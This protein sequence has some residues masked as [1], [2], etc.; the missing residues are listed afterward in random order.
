[1]DDCIS[2]NAIIL[3]GLAMLDLIKKKKKPEFFKTP[4]TLI[5]EFIHC[6]WQCEAEVRFI[7]Q[8]L[9]SSYVRMNGRVIVMLRNPSF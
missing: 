2:D 1:M 3:R 9:G 7:Q 5:I 4:P 6:Q 8:N